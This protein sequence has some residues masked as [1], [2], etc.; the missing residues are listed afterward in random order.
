MNCNKCNNT[1][2]A[3]RV[4]LGYKV[5][6]AC[7]DVEGY[8]CV[9]IVHHKTGNEIQIMTKDQ[10][11]SMSKFTRK[12]FGTVLKGGSKTDNYNPKNVK[13]RVPQ[14]P[15]VFIGNETTFKNV[16]E[17]MMV[18]LDAKGFDTASAYV[19]KQV[20]EYNIQATQAFKLKQLLSAVSA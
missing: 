19:D 1:I 10:A 9:D 16:G 17:M 13:I 12:R 15:T 2:P 14:G 8:G 5:C 4:D 3:K 6:V 7:S 11:K 18:L 20:K